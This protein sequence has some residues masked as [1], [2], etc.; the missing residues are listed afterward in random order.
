[1]SIEIKVPFPKYEGMEV[2]KVTADIE[3]GYSVVEYGE[4]E[5]NIEKDILVPESIGIYKYDYEHKF[6]S[7]DNLFI[8]FNNNT[9]LL[10]FCVNRWV[11][12]PNVYSNNRKIQCKLTPCKREELKE[13]DTGFCCHENKDFGDIMNYMKVLKDGAIDFVWIDDETNIYLCTEFNDPDYS[14]FK[15]EP[16]Q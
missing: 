7:G 12:Y 9:Q 1:M 10:G 16:I 11:V 2:K 13:G 5:P 15:V 8:G 14:F 6:N 3:N 4:K